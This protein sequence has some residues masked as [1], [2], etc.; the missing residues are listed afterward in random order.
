MFAAIAFLAVEVQLAMLFDSLGK[1]IRLVL[2]LFIL[3]ANGARH[4]AG[5]RFFIGPMLRASASCEDMI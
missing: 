2:L 1:I 4:P 3:L 5:K